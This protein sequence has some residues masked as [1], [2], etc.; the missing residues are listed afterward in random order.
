MESQLGRVLLQNAAPHRHNH[1][2]PA[3][4]EVLDALATTPNLHGAA[5][6]NHRE[7]FDA[8]VA[9]RHPRDRTQAIAICAGCPAL[10]A[11]AAWV[12]CLPPHRRPNGVIAGRYWAQR[13]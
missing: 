3:V 13:A 12:T 1:R 8:T 2:V 4:A 11:C 6:T 10:T 5:C 7:L 9:R